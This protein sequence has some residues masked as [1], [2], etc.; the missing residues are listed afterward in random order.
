MLSTS[1]K[2]LRTGCSLKQEFDKLTLFLKY[3]WN[4]GC[5]PGRASDL[6]G[7]LAHGKPFYSVNFTARDL[8]KRTQAA[9]RKAS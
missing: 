4:E 3:L 5:A 9:R 1:Q 6:H 8:T 2:P 7:A